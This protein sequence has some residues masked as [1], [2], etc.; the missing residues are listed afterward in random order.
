MRIRRADDNQPAVVKALRAV[1]AIVEPIHRLGRGVSDLLVS[2]DQRW[3]VLE[4][5]DGSKPPSAQKLTPDE[6]K[7]IAKQKAPVYIVRNEK[8]AV[9]VVTNL[10]RR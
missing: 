9:D 8:E 4:V 5:K 1:G 3:T 10:T 7:W 6:K 2:Y